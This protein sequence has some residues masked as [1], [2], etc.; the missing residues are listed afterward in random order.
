MRPSLSV[1][2]LR[3]IEAIVALGICAVLV[4]LVGLLFWA[5]IPLRP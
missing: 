1:R 3:A 4:F 2:V 5:L